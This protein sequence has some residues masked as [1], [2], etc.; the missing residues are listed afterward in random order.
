MPVPPLGPLSAVTMLTSPLLV[1][2][3]EPEAILI[4]PPDARLLTPAC[5]EMSPP[6]PLPPSPTLRAMWP[7]AAEVATPVLTST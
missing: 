6:F 2:E 7:P 5:I 3:P 4:L 1:V